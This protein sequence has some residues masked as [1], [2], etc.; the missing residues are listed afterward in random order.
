MRLDRQYHKHPPTPQIMSNTTT[1]G[2]PITMI[3]ALET[4]NAFGVDFEFLGG[5]GTGKRI[6]E[7][8]YD[9]NCFISYLLFSFFKLGHT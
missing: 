6:H 8:V 1:Q 5:L 3:L 7:L 9:F 4:F 2:T